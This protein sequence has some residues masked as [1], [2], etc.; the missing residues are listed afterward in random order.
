MSNHPQFTGQDLWSIWREALVSRNPNTPPIQF[1]NTDQS[2]QFAWSALAK[3]IQ[4]IGNVFR[5]PNSDNILLFRHRVGRFTITDELLQA[6]D[7]TMA[8]LFGNFVILDC[9]RAFGQLHGRAREYIALSE[10]FEV[11]PEDSPIPLYFINCTITRDEHGGSS[12]SFSAV[13][14]LSEET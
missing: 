7:P 5:K 1:A 11:T 2:H 4:Q 12:V 14:Q 13:R 8:A 3:Y 6:A 9:R 10:L